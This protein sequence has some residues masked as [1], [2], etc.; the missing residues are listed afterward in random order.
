MEN[1][2][3]LQELCERASSLGLSLFILSKSTTETIPPNVAVLFVPSFTENQRTFLLSCSSCLV[4]TPSFEHFGIVPV[5]AMYSQVPVI[6]V[7]N[8]GPKES[9][10]HGETGLLCESDTLSFSK[11]LSQLLLQKVIP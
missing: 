2:E 11:A 6:A 5:E 8:G 10:I 1:K 4:Y 7:N 3:Y 9:I